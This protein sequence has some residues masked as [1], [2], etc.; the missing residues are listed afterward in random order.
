MDRDY[1]SRMVNV[2]FPIVGSIS[3]KIRFSR[4][5]GEGSTEEDWERRREEAFKPV[6]YKR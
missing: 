1:L 6:K 2:N 4:C 5:G 3:G